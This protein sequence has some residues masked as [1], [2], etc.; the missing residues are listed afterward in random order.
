MVAHWQSVMTFCNT[1]RLTRV[2]KKKKK[3][4]FID[5]ILLSSPLPFAY[6]VV[7]FFLRLIFI[8]SSTKIIFFDFKTW[9]WS[10]ALMFRLHLFEKVLSCRFLS[11]NIWRND[12]I[13][14][15]FAVFCA[16][17]LL[18]VGCPFRKMALGLLALLPK[19]IPQF[20]QINW[21]KLLIS[22]LFFELRK[23]LGLHYAKFDTI[24][25]FL[26][27]FG[28]QKKKN[29][30]QFVWN[31]ANDWNSI[32]KK[33]QTKF[34]RGIQIWRRHTAVNYNDTLCPHRIYRP[35]FIS[36]TRTL[37]YHIV[38]LKMWIE[39]KAGKRLWYE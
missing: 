25:I 1:Q 16:D 4:F 2:W 24:T 26:G 18:F 32:Q 9:K 10:D 23:N 17:S 13:F 35:A 20:L 37:I 34:V 7:K 29:N 15:G 5:S 31:V 28:T 39:L 33:W 6:C 11:P 21:D 38:W 22:H 14:F 8:F 27:Y 36:F 3:Q 12:E 19:K 30:I